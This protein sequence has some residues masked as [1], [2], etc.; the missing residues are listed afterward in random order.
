MLSVPVS[1]LLVPYPLS[2]V[3]CH[4]VILSSAVDRPSAI[5]L[6]RPAPQFADILGDLRVVQ[7]LPC[8][9]AG[10]VGLTLG[11]RQAAAADAREVDQIDMLM[12]RT[13]VLKQDAVWLRQHADMS[14][15]A[16]LRQQLN[17][18]PRLLVNL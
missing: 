18:Q 14:E 15:R 3:S 11:V 7:R 12:L 17:V 16:A 4:L 2:P 6:D 13:D 5:A 9:P 10:R 1:C 8:E